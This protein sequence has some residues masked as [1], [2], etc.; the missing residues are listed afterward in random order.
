[1]CTTSFFGFWSNSALSASASCC[2]LRFHFSG[3][4]RQ[5]LQ[6]GL[7][8]C[9][10]RHRN[11]QPL[12]E[13]A[14]GARDFWCCVRCSPAGYFWEAQSA[15]P[16]DGNRPPRR[17]HAIVLL[18]LAALTLAA[19][20]EVALSFGRFPFTYG[21]RCFA[22]WLA[23]QGWMDT[24]S[25]TRSRSAECRDCRTATECRSSGSRP[26]S[27]GLGRVD[28]RCGVDCRWPNQR[29]HFAQRDSDVRTIELTA[30]QSRRTAKRILELRPSHCYVPLNLGITYDPRRLG[31]R[32]KE[33]RFRTVTGVETR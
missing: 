5:N 16:H 8:L 18:A 24:G 26:T 12:Y 33:L 15:N 25:A 14:A 4:A 29:H 30:A 32:V 21:Q 20:I 3:L 6:L 22:A 28:L 17:R 11:R 23:G 31:V 19:V 13:R 1:M 10:G 2:L 27:V 9:A 7:V